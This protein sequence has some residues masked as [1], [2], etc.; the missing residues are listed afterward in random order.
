MAT[1]ETVAPYGQESLRANY[2]P[3]YNAVLVELKDTIILTSLEDAQ[4]PKYAMKSIAYCTATKEYQCGRITQ[5][6][7]FDRLACDF[8]FP[9]QEVEASMLAVRRSMKIND[10]LVEEMTAIKS[11]SQDRIRFFAVANLSREDYEHAVGLGLDQTLFDQTLISSNLGMQKPELRFYRRV[12]SAIDVSA[13]QAILI[14]SDPDNVL[15]ALSLG[16]Q[17]A[18]SLHDS[19]SLRLQRLTRSNFSHD[20][21]DCKQ[22]SRRDSAF[23]NEDGAERCVYSVTEAVLQGTKFLKENAKTFRSYTSTG[24]AIDDN[25]AELIIL[26][27]T[28]DR[29]V[30]LQPRVNYVS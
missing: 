11:E 10:S 28:G 21:T 14:D 23:R 1:F 2:C 16:I 18:S 30:Q 19:L 3:S 25:F 8:K 4:L 20:D 27:I 26:E 17:H 6:Q 13:E 5:E 29:S 9:R 12:L 22:P 7:Y 24:V 15:A